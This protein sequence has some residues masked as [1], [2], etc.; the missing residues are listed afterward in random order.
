MKEE[1][2]YIFNHGQLLL[3]NNGQTY[4]IPRKPISA[5]KNLHLFGE[6][7]NLLLYTSESCANEVELP[8]GYEW[9]GLRE[10]F[11][12]L[13]RPIYI[14]AGKA[15]EI[16]YFDTH[17]QYCGICGAHMEWHTPISKRCEVCGEEIWPQL[18][19]AII[20]LVHRGEE[21]LL[22]KAKSFRRNFY[23]LVAGFVETGESLE[24]CVRREVYEETGLT[25]G[26]IRYFGSQPWPYPMGLMVGF[27][28]DYVS[29]DIALIDGELREAAFFRRDNLPTIPE[30]LSMARMLIDDWVEG[31]VFSV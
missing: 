25:I 14:E 11:N 28:A 20:V 5:I 21:A 13:P 31:L 16:L 10:S 9:I 24:E 29:G 15:S 7:D 4:E 1:R 27:H 18:N 26:N 12:L 17:H 2:H 6:H 19:T 8:Q 22:V 3:K 30:K 23:G